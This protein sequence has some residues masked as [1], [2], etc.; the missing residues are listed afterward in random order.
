MHEEALHERIQAAVASHF[1]EKFADVD[2][3]ALHDIEKNLMIQLLDQHWKEHLAGMDHLRQGI[4]LRGYAQKNPAQEFKRESFEMF[5][6][7]MASIRYEFVSTLCRIEFK[8]QP[9][10]APQSHI[11][12]NLSYQHAEFGGIP[13]EPVQQDMPAEMQMNDEQ[14]P[15]Q[16]F[17]RGQKKVGRNEPCPCGSGKKYKQCHGK[18]S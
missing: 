9:E 6:Q 11:A 4:H 14:E 2:P 5:K 3:K 12:P 16:P 7:M 10:M 15:Y 18:I 17:V 8:E 13:A 1:D